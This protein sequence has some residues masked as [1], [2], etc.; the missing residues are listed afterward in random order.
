LDNSSLSQLLLPSIVATP[1]LVFLGLSLAWLVGFNPPERITSRLIIAAYGFAGLA[2][3]WLLWLMRAAGVN[4]LNI[5]MGNWYAVHEFKIPLVLFVDRLSIPLVALTIILVGIVASFSRSY[6]HRD[7][8]FQRFFLLLNLFAFG[9]LLLFTAG[10]FDLLIAGWEIV[11]ITSVLLIAF[12]QQRPEPVRSA[13]RVYATY[14]GCDIGIMIGVI[15]LHNI[16]GSTS[17]QTIFTGAWP[18]QGLALTGGGATL[19]GLLLLL[20]ASG[21]SAQVPFSG[22]LPR[23]MEGPTPSSAIFYGA[24]SVHAGAYLL[25]R[26]QPILAASPVASGAVIL[27]GLLSA[28]HG[29]MVARACSDAKTSLAY[30]SIS[31]LGIIFME[32][33]FGLS[34]LALLHI[35]GHAIVRTLQFL[36]APSM[37]HD[38]H[39][40]HAAAGGHLARTGTHYEAVLPSG[41][42]LWLYR[43]A[44]DRGHH[45]AILDRFLIGP[46]R[47]AAY[48]MA[49][50][51]KRWTN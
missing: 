47:R 23:A 17:Y 3:V 48:T 2:F 27:V 11:C 37:L 12:F 34:W 15:V 38:F 25:L 46:L 45:D 50:L 10:S 44:L 20:A 24:I 14:R 36:R 49:S 32:I 26:A 42:Q 18:A 7:R 51:E 21:K 30:A 19:I 29:T 33:G 6:V 43:L 22:W 16:A 1:G 31:Q 4:T 13:I 41:A 9:S 39:G 40:V 8:G 28:I 35:I 5:E